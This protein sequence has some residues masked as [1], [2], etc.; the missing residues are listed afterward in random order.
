MVMMNSKNDMGFLTLRGRM[1]AD[2]AEFAEVPLGVEIVSDKQP[3][4]CVV[5][6]SVAVCLIDV[7]SQN[8]GVCQV[9]LP[10]K[11]EHQRD[12]AMLKA[13]SQLETLSN[14]LFEAVR[15]VGREPKL[16]AKIFGGAEIGKSTLS[17]SDGKQSTLF[18][19]SWLQTKKIQIISKSIGGL[20]RREIV[21]VP[22]TGQVFCKQVSMSS[23][24]L[25]QERE[26]LLS[27]TGPRNKVELF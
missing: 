1:P 22:Q 25:C 2:F 4:Y 14:K 8:A 19:C 5:G 18:V 27:L 3:L 26:E 9:M 12:D 24:F 7:G 23:E 21:L 16:L 17:F 10:A 13:D 15:A 20:K 11:F 6:A